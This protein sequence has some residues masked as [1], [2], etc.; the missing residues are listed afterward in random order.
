MLKYTIKIKPI[1]NIGD[2]CEVSNCRPVSLSNC[3]PVSQ[4]NCRP[5]SLSNCRPV[6]LLTSLST[7]FE[8]VMQTRILK[9]LIEYNTVSTEQYGLR[10]RLK[11]DNEICKLTSEIL[12]V[13]NNKLLV[14]RIL[15]DLEKVLIVMIMVLYYLN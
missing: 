2:R 9:H 11:T 7:I 12:Y 14:G 4:S 6:S 1:H 5:V 15:C 8:M 3:R 10:T 13:T